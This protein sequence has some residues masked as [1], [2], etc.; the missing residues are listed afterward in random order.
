[1]IN[2]EK[3]ILDAR[4]IALTLLMSCLFSLSSTIVADPTHKKRIIIIDSQ[5]GA[6][7]EAVRQSMLDKLKEM[8]YNKKNGFVSEYYSLSHYHGAA[9]NLW[10]HRMSKTDY[11]AIFLN[12]TLA[13]ASFKEIAWKN[14]D[15][16]FIYA[17]VTDPVGLALVTEYDHPPTGNFSGIAYHVPIDIRMAFVKS[18]LPNVKSIGFV[19]ANMPQSISYRKWIEAL[20]EQPEWKNVNFHFRTVDFIP[21][22]GGHHRMAQI[23]KKYIK[24]LDPIVDVFLSPSDQMGAQPPFAKM[25]FDVATKPLIGIG[26]HDVVEGWGATA[27]IHPSE[28]AMGAQ[29]AVMIDRILKGES[30]NT[31][32]PMMPAHYGMVIDKSKAEKF[33]IELSQKL[34]NGA[35]IIQ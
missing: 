13:V 1:M 24:E 10:K 23:A 2:S 7:Y 5:A 29:A 20:K 22:D 11:D 6:P 3:F 12:G 17:T 19:Y 27:S 34:L 14:P 21:S 8:G 33:G 16:Q 25:V 9:K 18:L 15:Y 30:I 31:I 35:E 26:N 32:N 28:T 4:K